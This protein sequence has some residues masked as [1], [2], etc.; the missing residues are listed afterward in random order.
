MSVGTTNPFYSKPYALARIKQGPL[1]SYIDGFA[2][3]LRECGY[4]L[5]IG[6]D[7]VRYIGYFSQWMEKHCY[8]VRQLNEHMIDDYIQQLKHHSNVLASSAPYRLFLSYLR[9]VGI[10]KR[11]PPQKLSKIDRVINE[12]IGHLRQERGLAE[13][14]LPHRRIFVQRFL[15]DHF[16][17]GASVRL[18][19]LKAQ[20]FIRHIRRFANVY[21]VMYRGNQVLVLRDFCR[22]LRQ[23][24]YIHED[25]ASSIPRIPYWKSYELPTPLK[26][27]E[28]EHL[29]KN[30]EHETPKE[31]RD[32]AI[33]LLLTRLG[34]RA[35]EVRNLTLDDIDWEMGQI[36]VCGKGSK[37]NCLP[38]PHEVGKAVVEYLQNGRPP[39]SSRYVFIRARAPFTK[40]ACS[41]AIYKVV[42]RALKQADLHPPH[43]GPHLLRHTFAT[44]LLHRGAVLSEVS[45]MLGHE[46]INSTMVYAQI[47]Q[48]ELKLVT[49]PW[50]GGAK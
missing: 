49:Q 24:G 19:H 46:D 20:D 11:L 36:T 29:L 40:M 15:N 41:G 7:Y 31:M 26:P 25:I 18:S 21:S 27:S 16:S 30:C 5:G 38:L 33:L 17:N 34:L 47:D 37:R 23:Q 10:I 2:R 13:Q 8:K 3:R 35:G 12:Y 44:N 50:P 43:K 48:S 45:R 4:S 14:T 6:N 28:V 1:S 39:C 22:F 42:K 9:E 32:Y